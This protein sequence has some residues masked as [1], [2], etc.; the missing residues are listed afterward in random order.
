M[1]L[2]DTLYP[3]SIGFSLACHKNIKVAEFML[4]Y[5][6]I[7]E[8][9]VARMCL[10]LCMEC[11]TTMAGLK[12]LGF[13][14]EK[15]EFHAYANGR[16]P[17]ET[18][19]PD[20]V[21]KNLLLSVQ[22][23]KIGA[24]LHHVCGKH[25]T[26][27]AVEGGLWHTFTRHDDVIDTYIARKLSRSGRESR[28]KDFITGKEK[29]TVTVGEEY[30]NQ[31][32]GAKRVLGHVVE[33]DLWKMKRCL[34]GEMS[35]VCGVATIMERL[36]SWG[37]GEIKVQRMGGN[38]FLLTLEDDELFTMLEDLDWSYLKEIFTKVEPWSKKMTIPACATW[39]ELTGVPL[40]CWNHVT[41]RRIA[42]LWGHFEA[43][44]ENKNHLI[45][46]EKVSVLVT[47]NHKGKIEEVIE[48][49]V[50][51]RVYAERVEEIGCK[52]RMMIDQES[53]KKQTSET[54]KS[55][56][57][58]ESQ[59][60]SESATEETKSRSPDCLGRSQE[61][62]WETVNVSFK[63]KD[64]MGNENFTIFDSKIGDFNRH[65]GEEEMQGHPRSHPT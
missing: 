9:E 50:G 61:E 30:R 24:R 15:D 49:G 14:F 21:L 42:E 47:M 48:L 16:L 54:G 40:H 55:I 19:R 33:E 20:S 27:H 2:D 38:A 46:C 62:Q 39:L 4:K 35:I 57:E 8:S 34:V 56:H 10:E 52:E 59:S 64:C 60:E 5:L 12:A 51:S 53:T 18:L 63:G 37:L 58:E 36:T 31:E 1:D 3:L 11:G 22:Q 25:T 7:E 6:D 28:K 43:F 65:L 29:I 23:R 32:K 26:S 41:I 44:G 13:E 45:D 17:Y